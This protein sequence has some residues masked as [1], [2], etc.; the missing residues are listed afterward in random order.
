MP[1]MP[2][3]IGISELRLRQ[4]EVLGKLHAGPVLL[5]Q[6]SRAVAVLV[7]P[8]QWNELMEELEDLQDI[9]AAKEARAEAEPSMGLEEY[10]RLRSQHVSRQAE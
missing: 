4:N 10:A 6:R 5:T 3:L 2:E 7:S 8:K 9:I 1:A